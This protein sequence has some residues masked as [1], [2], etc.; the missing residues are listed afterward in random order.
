MVRVGRRRKPGMAAFYNATAENPNPL[1]VAGRFVAGQRGASP[2]EEDERIAAY[3]EH[4]LEGLLQRESVC[5]SQLF[6]CVPL[7]SHAR[8][9]QGLLQCVCVCQ[10]S[11]CSSSQGPPFSP[12]A[13]PPLTALSP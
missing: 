4:S 5:V 8:L 1:A 2:Q 12:P 9:L 13:S 11:S 3:E 10:Q 7:S 6:S